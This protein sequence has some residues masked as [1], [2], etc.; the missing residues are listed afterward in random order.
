MG[1]VSLAKKLISVL[2][3]SMAFV[4]APTFAATN[5][6]DMMQKKADK[7][8]DNVQHNVDKQKAAKDVTKKPK[9]KMQNKPKPQQQ[10]L[11]DIPDPIDL[12]S[13]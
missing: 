1:K 8:T 7:S 13:D 9:P 3:I 10:Q 11:K 6:S 5:T 12:N 2:G 4:A